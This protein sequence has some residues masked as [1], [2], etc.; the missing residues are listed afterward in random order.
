MKIARHT[1][2]DFSARLR[3]L[4]AD[5]SL[6]DVE[7]ESRTCQ[8]LDAVYTCGDDALLECTERFDGAKLTVEQL[9]VTQ[10]EL[11]NASACR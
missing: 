2:K 3:E 11:F 1:D 8:I 6:F 9:A 5:S 10:A 4:T 7:I